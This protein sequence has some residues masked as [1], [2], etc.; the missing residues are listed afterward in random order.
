MTL[1]NRIFIAFIALGAVLIAL[2]LVFT[3]PDK[4]SET[5]Q[6]AE[7]PKTDTPSARPVQERAPSVETIIAALPQERLRADLEKFYAENEYRPLWMNDRAGR[8]RLTAIRDITTMLNAQG[9]DPAFLENAKAA[10]SSA[11]TPDESLRADV[12]M[13]SAL[14]RT[15]QGQRFGFVPA[16]DLHWHLAADQVEVASFLGQAVVRNDIASYF[17]SLRPTHPQYGALTEALGRYR[18]IAAAGGWPTVPEGKEIDFT[19]DARLPVLRDRL[20]AE[21][22]LS[23]DAPTDGVQLQEAVKA[24]QARNGLEP[25]G[26]AGSGTVAALNVSV[27]QRIDQIL[28]NLER[29]RHMR[30]EEP[31]T[32]VMVNVADQSVAVVRDGREELRLRTIVGAR[33]HA[34]PML[35][36]KVTAVTLNPPW[37]IPTSIITNEILPKLDDEPYY[38]E[39][40]DM[41]VVGGSWD[42][43]KSLRLRQRPG[44]GN[45]LGHMKFQMQNEWNI[46]LH[47]TPARALF[48]KTDRYFSHGC[49]RVDQPHELAMKL[50]PGWDLDK[51][52]EGI[53]SGETRTIKVDTPAPVFVLY[54]TA[55]ADQDGRLHFRRDAYGR[56]SVTAAALARAGVFPRKSE[57]V[58]SSN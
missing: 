51:L 24:Y 39:D 30:H 1:R 43:P 33:R 15:A 41:D 17:S 45:S 36:A 10:L 31:D 28:A 12:E 48:A 2:A 4:R 42:N 20:A 9:I 29:W 7:A 13:S 32:Y 27:D 16:Q 37:E 8:R 53:A 18:E 26:R 35:E 38:L 22:Y 40:N 47:D 5:P 25:D 50:L 49:V 55:F 3:L 6:V 23:P 56:D 54:W 11:R 21:G 19:N 46:Y 58:P 34:T 14:L 57:V 44:T 52:N